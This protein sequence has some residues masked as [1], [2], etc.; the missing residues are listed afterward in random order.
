M[1]LLNI[2]YRLPVSFIQHSADIL[3]KLSS[4]GLVSALNALPQGKL[5]LK[6]L[7]IAD[8]SLGEWQKGAMQYDGGFDLHPLFLNEKL[9]KQFYEG[10]SNSVLWPLFHYFPSFVEYTDEYFN[11]FIKANEQIADKAQQLV[12]GGDTIWIHDYHLLPL[13]ALLR[14]LNPNVTIGFF[15]HT[16]FPNYELIRLLPKKCR[17]FLIDGVLGA[18]VIGF[19]TYD[20]VHHF[21]DSV[22]RIKG[23]QHKQFNILYQNRNIKVGAFPISIDFNK[24]YNA[25][26]ELP[27]T[28]ERNKLKQQYGDMK[29]IFS[30][31]RLDYTKG[32]LNRLKGYRRF[33]EEYPEWL[34]KI[35]FILVLIPSRTAVKKYS[36]RRRMI[37]EMVSSINGKL[38]NYKWT[39]IIFQLSSLDYKD[40]L[41]LYTG[42]DI[43]LISPVR[44]GMNLVAKEFVASRKLANGVL[45]LSNLTG[46]ASELSQALLFNPLDEQEIA[47]KIHQALNMPEREQA[48][49]M[50]SMQT[51]IKKHDVYRWADSFVSELAQY[52]HKKTTLLFD[53]GSRVNL[54]H[55]FNAAE[56]R[57]IVLDYDGTLVSFQSSP[58]LA[59]P[60]DELLEL[61]FKLSGNAKN[62]IAIASGRDKNTLEKWFGHL[63]ITLIAEHGAY[64]RRKKWCELVTDTLSW[65]EE[66]KRIMQLFEDRCPGAF[67]EEKMFSLAWHY[68]NSDS[69]IGQAKALELIG[70]LQS[71][72]ENTNTTVLGG[73][74]VVEV[75]PASINKGNALRQIFGLSD[76]NCCIAIGDDKT[77]EDMFHV[78]NQQKN[79]YTFKVGKDSSAAKY[80][81]D[82]TGQVISFLHQLN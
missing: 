22:K 19:Q 61:L 80:R 31:D 42:C 27:V 56:K 41:G 69:G 45:M 77:D 62:E 44:D 53:Y 5:N 67:L 58:E 51:Q 38:G 28:A 73:N 30:V 43:A 29:I 49:R 35:V 7:G 76:F 39:P 26:N 59:I 14:K 47:S 37:E 82:T 3:I 63:P 54:L 15:L 24:F 72:L 66:V 81:L 68:R 11:A 10:F 79:G 34:G 32:I 40:L 2:T 57:L 65:K 16:P 33:L 9:N 74:K 23:I 13:A 75:K 71:Y 4:G 12:K 25:Y 18:D 46:A 64:Y 1:E 6:W 70:I 50:T 20:Y 36:E 21:L 48:E 17:Q 78:V 60:P 8:F 55:S 52:A